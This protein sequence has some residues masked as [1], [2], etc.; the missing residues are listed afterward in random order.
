MGSM[1]SGKGAKVERREQRILAIWYA[2]QTKAKYELAVVGEENWEDCTH[3]SAHAMAQSSCV[4][5]ERWEM[6]LTV[7]RGKLVFVVLWS[8]ANQHECRRMRQCFF[9]RYAIL[10]IVRGEH[11]WLLSGE[12]LSH[13]T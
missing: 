8:Y 3:V 2:A 6:R 5:D 9:T 10:K 12:Q 1:R 4:Q 11:R 13:S 7:S